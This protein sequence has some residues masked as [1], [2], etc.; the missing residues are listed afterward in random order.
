[1]KPKEAAMEKDEYEKA[2]SEDGDQ[3]GPIESA[4]EAAAKKAKREED[5]EFLTAYAELEKK[6]GGK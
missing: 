2:W 3:A 1:M 6:D 5:D 4:V